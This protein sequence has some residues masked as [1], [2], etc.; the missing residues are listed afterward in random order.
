MVIDAIAAEYMGAELGDKRRS[1]RLVQLAEQMGRMPSAS[2]PK[3]LEVS[4]LEGAY[5]LL[6]NPAV[7]A[8]EM[9]VPHVEATL[10]RIGDQT[11]LAVHDTTTMSFRADGKRRGFA[12]DAST[13]TQQFWTHVTLAVAADGTRRP[14]G[15]LRVSSD[16][17]I[18][19]NRWRIHVEDVSKFGRDVV[20]L[21]DREA[22][23]Y[24]LF[25]AL[26]ADDER[27]VI[28]LEHDRVL[29]KRAREAT[30]RLTDTVQGAQCIER[31][32]TLGTR[33]E[34]QGS[35]QRRVHPARKGR[36]ALL[37]IA[38]ARVRLQRPRNQRK[39]LPDA[40]ELTFVRA[41]E[42]NPPPGEKHVDWMLITSEPA[43]IEAAVRAVDWYRARWM[44]EEFFKALKT[45]CAI[46]Q[47]QLE[48]FDA[49]TKAVALFAPIAWHLLL[50]RHD[51]RHAPDRR[52]V[53]VLSSDQLAALRAAS[54]RP[55]PE[56]PTARDVALAIAALGGHLRNNGEPGWLTLARGYD[57][58]RLIALGWTL[59]RSDQS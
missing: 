24:A 27:F 52:A 9:L 6:R 29:S 45:G 37:T 22:D 47:R 38:T 15:V 46:E 42:R 8:E 33:A 4:E 50:I 7:G 13:K 12:Y 31:R 36:E 10:A 44:V 53:D 2:F 40:L 48:T 19:H 32:V 54:R 3:A 26:V 25:A 55:I 5:R 18:D 30:L 23:D 14:Y 28:R 17:K 11:V 51:A 59:A 16:I 34:P 49:L 56:Q 1:A 41:W 35:K 21:M 58:L 43:D 57:H 20:H 39:S